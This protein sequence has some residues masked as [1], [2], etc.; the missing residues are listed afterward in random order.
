MC[1]LKSHHTGERW[2]PGL[3]G[4]AFLF[5]I[6]GIKDKY[7]TCDVLRATFERSMDGLVRSSCKLGSKYPAVG[8]GQL[9]KSQC[10][11][12][13]ALTEALCKY[14]KY[15]D[16]RPGQLSSTVAVCHCCDVFVRMATGA[17]KSLC[18]FV[19][20]LAIGDPAM[21]I[22]IS[23]PIALMDQQVHVTCVKMLA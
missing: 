18:L 14:F 21:G 3:C 20:P 22:I 6:I 9:E 1:S 4:H 10:P 2:Y 7:I 8:L 19:L 12:V 17:G 11:V 13:Q 16:F 15:K 5:C 23:P